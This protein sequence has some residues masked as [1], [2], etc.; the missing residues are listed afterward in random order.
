MTILPALS[1][2]PA[3]FALPARLQ[4]L[5]RKPAAARA[6]QEPSDFFRAG[7]RRNIK[8]DAFGIIHFAGE[9]SIA[10]PERAASAFRLPLATFS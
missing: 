10:P 1:D 2:L 4:D 8:V 7:G 5:A 3:L 6:K 9:V